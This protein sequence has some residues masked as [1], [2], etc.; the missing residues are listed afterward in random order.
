MITIRGQ[1]LVSR[2]GDDPVPPCVHSK[3]TRVYVQNVPVCTGTARTR[4]NTCGRGAGTH[5]DVLNVRTEERF[6][7][8]HGERSGCVCGGGVGERWSA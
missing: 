7:P 3:H 5:G 8:T 6:E 4:G 1:I 2:T